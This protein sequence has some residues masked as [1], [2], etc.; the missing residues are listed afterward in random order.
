MIL[1]LSLLDVEEKVEEEVLSFV[2]SG[3]PENGIFA[4]NDTIFVKFVYTTHCVIYTLDC[5]C[6]ACV[7]YNSD[8]CG[9]DVC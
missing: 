7:Q 2:E 8:I 1:C 5:T 4:E 9:N 6:C 3:N